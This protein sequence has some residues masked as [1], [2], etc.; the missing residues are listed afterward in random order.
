MLVR[1]V[2][3]PVHYFVCLFFCSILF[4][5]CEHIILEA[6][7]VSPV[8]QAVLASCNYHRW[9]SM[10]RT[11]KRASCHAPWAL[12]RRAPLCTKVFFPHRVAEC[13]SCT[14]AEA[15]T[16]LQPPAAASC[17][18]PSELRSGKASPLRRRVSSCRNPHKPLADRPRQSGETVHTYH[19]R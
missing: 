10:P 3:V 9:A 18:R 17:L 1:Y 5:G 12:V 6:V 8:R 15:S 7:A 4:K 19:L 14:T 2:D 11:D 16:H 13:G